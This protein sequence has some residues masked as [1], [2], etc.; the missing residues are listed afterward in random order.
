MQV[1]EEMSLKM[2]H[3]VDLHLALHPWSEFDVICYL[4]PNLPTYM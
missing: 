4:F 2:T 1:G 3:V